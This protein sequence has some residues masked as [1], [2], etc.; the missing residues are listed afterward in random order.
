MRSVKNA[1]SK[2]ILKY[3]NMLLF[4]NFIANSI[5]PIIAL[6]TKNNVF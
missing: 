6:V 1:K 4:H 3:F 2:E 5:S